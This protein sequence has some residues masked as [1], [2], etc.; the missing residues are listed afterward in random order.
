MADE[1]DS[2]ELE[3]AE[4]STIATAKTKRAVVKQKP[5]RKYKVRLSNMGGNLL[6]VVM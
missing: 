1:N 5:L 4:R 3:L 2:G 6:F